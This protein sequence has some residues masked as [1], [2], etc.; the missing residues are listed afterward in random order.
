MI[1]NSYAVL[2]GFLSL[3]RVILGLS[4]CWL[5]VAA[6]RAH[7]AGSTPEAREK[8]EDQ[9]YLLFLMAFV[10]LGLNVLSWPVFYLLLQSYVPEWPGV[11]CI[12]GVTQI[13]A[14]SVGSSRFLPDLVRLLQGTKPLLVFTS[15]AWFVLYLLNRRT[16]TAPLTGRILLLLIV[17]AALSVTDAVAE[18]AYLVIPKKE[19]TLSVGCCTAAFDRSARGSRFLPGVLVEEQ[20]RR[21]LCGAYYA[22]NLGVALALFACRRLR[23]RQDLG[24]WTGPLLALLAL[25]VGISGLFLIE[26]AAPVLL[27]LPYHHCP[28]D[29]L[30]RVPES[31]APIA[32]FVLGAFAVGWACSAQWGGRHEETETY[33]PIVEFNLLG[34]GLFGYLT[35]LFLMSIEL[36]LA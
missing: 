18:T 21:W 10:A 6:W 30:P 13:G 36:A 1:L 16:R 27:H 3:I 29:L 31:M 33:L 22:V 12:Y 24:G 9:S 8:L 15:G 26:V 7:R 11:M 14:G 4:M 35:S 32:L 17:F 25:S 5:S 28:Y 20:Y 23:Q 2:D 34:L 19:E